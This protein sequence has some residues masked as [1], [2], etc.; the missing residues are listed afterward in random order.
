VKVWKILPFDSNMTLMTVTD[1]ISTYDFKGIPLES[2][3][4]ITLKAGKKGKTQDYAFFGGGV[5][6]FNNRSLTALEDL[7]KGNVQLLDL[8]VKKYDMEFKFVNVT[9]VIDAIDYSKSIARRS[10]SGKLTS[11]EKISFLPESV[12]DQNIFKIPE[13]PVTP[14]FVSDRFKN[15][16]EFAKLKGFDFIEVWDSERTDDILHAELEKYNNLLSEIERMKG[17]EFDWSAAVKKVE[18]GKI[19]ASGGWK[20]EKDKNG[21]F[22]VARLNL[23]CKYSWINSDIIPPI[24]LG[25][26][27]HETDGENFLLPKN[28]KENHGFYSM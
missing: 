24:L 15:T 27:W 19:V 26:K 17:E 4:G 13:M 28:E 9:N 22:Q 1:N 5:P 11:F 23:D 14:V 6:V 20:M 16:V 8:K 3:E 21:N 18:E 25:L 7:M 10:L 2:W 12:A